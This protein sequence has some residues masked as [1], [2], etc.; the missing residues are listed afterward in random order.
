MVSGFV[1]SSIDDTLTPIPYYG[2]DN[3]LMVV[4]GVY[5]G[6]QIIVE[7]DYWLTVDQEKLEDGIEPTTTHI[8]EVCDRK[9][10]IVSKINSKRGLLG[11]HQPLHGSTTSYRVRKT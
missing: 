11:E 8:L 10:L 4:D 1:Q 9:S 3:A 6:E 7:S 5:G 2:E